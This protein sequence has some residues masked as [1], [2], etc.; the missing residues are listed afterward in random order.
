M[1]NILVKQIDE[2]ATQREVIIMGDFNYPEI[3]WGTETCSSSKGLVIGAAVSLSQVKQILLKKVSK[4]PQDKTKIFQA[5]LQQLST[6]AGEQIRSMASL[7]GHV[8]SKGATSDLNPVLAAGGAM[9]NLVSK[10]GIRTIPLNEAF[11]TGSSALKPGEVLISVLIPYSPKEQFI[12]AFRQAQREENAFAIVNAGMQVQFKNGTDVIKQI[13]IYYGGIGPTTVPAKNTCQALTGSIA[14]PLTDLTK[15]GADVVN[16]SSAAVEAFQE[17]KRRFSSAPM[18]CQPDVSLP[19][20]VEVDAS[21]IGAGAVLSQRDSDC[22]MMKP[23][24]FFSRKF[25]PAERNYDVGNQELLAMKW[26]FEE[27]RHWLEGAKH[28]VVVLTDHK[29]LT[30]IE[31]AKRLNPRQAR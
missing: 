14:K 6:L 13:A 17:L 22:S 11:F 25:S 18:L 20:Q 23:C 2:A 1:E 10:G 30:Y 7:G 31:Y 26:A 15:K 3:D 21:E 28:R 5:L 29:N 9:L 12:S 19:F 8:I 27:W 24:A 4:L 16:W